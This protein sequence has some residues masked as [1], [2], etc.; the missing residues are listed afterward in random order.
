MLLSFLICFGLFF[1]GFSLTGLLLFLI[2]IW[3]NLDNCSEN[4]QIC[5]LA[6]LITTTITTIIGYVGFMLIIIMGMINLCVS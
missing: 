6:I 1:G 5:I 2:I 3:P 4:A